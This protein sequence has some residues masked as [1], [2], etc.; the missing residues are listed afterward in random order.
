MLRLHPDK[1]PAE[2]ATEKFQKFMH[3][4]DRWEATKSAPTAQHVPTTP[5]STPPTRAPPAQAQNL[6]T[7]AVSTSERTQPVTAQDE[8]DWERFLQISNGRFSIR[9][10]QFNLEHVNVRMKLFVIDFG[11]FKKV[12]F[13]FEGGIVFRKFG[14]TYV[15]GGIDYGNMREKHSQQLG[16]EATTGRQLET[17]N[18]WDSFVLQQFLSEEQPI[19]E[20]H[21]GDSSEHDLIKF[22]TISE[23]NMLRL[24]AKFYKG[25][26]ATAAILNFEQPIYFDT[27][28]AF[29]LRKTQS[30]DVKVDRFGAEVM[31]N[32]EK[33]NLN[34]LL[35]ETLDL[36]L[37]TLSALAYE[38][39]N[40]P[41]NDVHIIVRFN[42]KYK[43]AVNI[44][45]DIPHRVE[46]FLSGQLYEGFDL[47]HVRS[48]LDNFTKESRKQFVDIINSHFR[49]VG[50]EPQMKRNSLAP[51]PARQVAPRQAAPRQAAPRQAQPRQV[52]LK[53]C[54]D[55]RPCEICSSTNCW[56]HLRGQIRHGVCGTTHFAQC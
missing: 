20:L 45:I 31:N 34:K 39:P 9:N 30:G 28:E 14:R 25:R 21:H 40:L 16:W 29:G 52:G 2:D 55:A 43:K 47:P 49:D 35:V 22:L 15:S 7:Y 26:D 46:F 27:T 1:N 5:S 6:S 44:I 3:C 10:Q 37:Q 11:V 51:P 4:V 12:P 53:D 8:R 32:E 41:Y 19:F 54:A 33:H 23:E 56:G 50:N 48:V 38:D 24:C 42:K 13:S 17:I 18:P 36:N